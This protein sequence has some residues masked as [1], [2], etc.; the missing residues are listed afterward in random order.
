MG[1][2]MHGLHCRS[3]EVWASQSKQSIT[4]SIAS[5][6]LP[7]N[8]VKA[9]HLIQTIP[10]TMQS[11][12]RTVESDTYKKVRQFYTITIGDNLPTYTINGIN[13]QVHR[14]P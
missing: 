11:H 4:Y 8:M 1:I 7:T 10:D 13:R 12:L 9:T 3:S 2:M 6:F 5:S 14:K